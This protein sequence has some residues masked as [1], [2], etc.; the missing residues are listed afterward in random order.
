M[1]GRYLLDTNIL[2]RVAVEPHGST[3]ARLLQ[4][5]EARLCTS[6]IVSCELKFGLLKKGSARLTAQVE[7]LLAV[8]PVLPLDGEVDEQYARLRYALEK[9]GQP[10]GQNDLLIAAHAVAI[11]AVLVSDNEREFRK[12]PG[13]RVENWSPRR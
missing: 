9:R 3:A 8:V 1:A 11:D 10:I 6:V 12:V 2:S 13:L 7:A 5:G 4:A